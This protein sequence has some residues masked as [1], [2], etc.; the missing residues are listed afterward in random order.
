[1]CASSVVG[2]SL[3]AANGLVDV[4]DRSVAPATYLVSKEP[5]P[6]RPV[7]AHRTFGD[8]A[9]LLAVCAPDGRLLDYESGRCNAHVKGRVVK[10]AHRSTLS[11]CGNRLE[12]ATVE[13][14]EMATSTERQ[15]I[16]VDRALLGTCR[17]RE[18]RADTGGCHSAKMVR[19]R[20]CATPR[21]ELLDLDLGFVGV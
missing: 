2:Q 1:L 17:G 20:A 18:G 14:N 9:T 15:P 13:S 5:K 3:R 19:A 12:Q 21:P 16:Q 10:V 6:T 8:N 4:G 7:A 11:P